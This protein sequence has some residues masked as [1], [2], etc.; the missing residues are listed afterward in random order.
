MPEGRSASCRLTLGSAIA[1]P[2]LPESLLVAQ[3]R[4]L[5]EIHRRNGWT[6]EAFASGS[7]RLDGLDTSLSVAD[8]DADVRFRA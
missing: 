1:I 2:S 6:A 4:P 8:V 5:I 3:D 7:L